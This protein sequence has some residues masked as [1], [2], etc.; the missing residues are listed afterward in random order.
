MRLEI[1]TIRLLCYLGF[2]A[3]VQMILPNF[4]GFS[5]VI[6]YAGR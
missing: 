5:Q 3:T 2:D 6:Y 4:I 1:K